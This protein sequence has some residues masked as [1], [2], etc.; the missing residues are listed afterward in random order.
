[1][2][3]WDD[4][5]SSAEYVYGKKPNAFLVEQLS[6]LPHGTILFPCEGEGRNAVYA[7]Q[8]GFTVSAFDGSAEGKK[9][10]LALANES[11]VTINYAVDDAMHIEYAHESFDIIVLIF[12]HFPADIRKKIHQRIVGWLKPGGTILLEAFQP[13]QMPLTS[14]GPKDISMLYTSDM[15]FDD[16]EKMDDIVIAHESII[17]DEGPLHQG[18]AEV[19]RMIAKK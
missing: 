9:K 18:K 15:L 16:F 10:A 2:S 14:G 12:A 17:L 19:I 4:R 1:M 11:G 5:Y 7:A 6:H 8:Q 3:Q 13:L